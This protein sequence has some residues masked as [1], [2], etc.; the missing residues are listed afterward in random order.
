MDVYKD[1]SKA[2]FRLNDFLDKFVAANQKLIADHQ[3]KLRARKRT[4][5]V[6]PPRIFYRMTNIMAE[7]LD[8]FRTTHLKPVT[9]TKSY[10]IFG[11]Y[12]KVDDFSRISY[13]GRLKTTGTSFLM[14]RV[15]PI[16]ASNRD[17]DNL[18]RFEVLA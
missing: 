8:I 15:L 4:R 6:V 9:A 12:S 3:R 18:K 14:E 5:R 11:Y 13:D 1:A 17:F 10:T 2:F 7:I 16:C